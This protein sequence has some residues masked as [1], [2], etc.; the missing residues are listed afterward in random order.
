MPF[1]RHAGADDLVRPPFA[2]RACRRRR[3]ASTIDISATILDRVGL[4][5]YH[6]MR[7]TSLLPVM[8]VAAS[9]VMR[10]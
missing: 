2:R 6:G 3:A 10:C 9:I 1:V 8:K 7:G 4:V 5:P